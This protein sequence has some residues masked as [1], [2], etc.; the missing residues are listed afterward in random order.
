MKK[1]SNA[2]EAGVAIVRIIVGV[3]LVLHGAEVFQT[4][5]MRSYGPWM[6]DL[7]VPFALPL[8]YGGKIS[9]LVGGVCLITGLL[10]K[11][12]CILLMLTFLFIVVVMGGGKILTDAQH[13]FMFFLFSLLFYLAGDSEYT[14]RRLFR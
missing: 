3:L 9:E 2:S 11:P 10:L 8:A 13:A 1:L 5:E 4:D 6:A 14:I 12:A 7:G